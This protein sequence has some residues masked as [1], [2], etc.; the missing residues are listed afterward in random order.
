MGTQPVSP[1]RDPGRA[2]AAATAAG[3][4]VI[5]LK[6]A[7]LRVEFFDVGAVIVFLRKVIWIV[8]GFTVSAYLEPLRALHERIEADGSVV[9][10]STRFL[11]EARRGR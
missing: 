1:V 8:P 10:H 3:L 7:S 11:I 4:N 5:D 2:V 9:A 6:T